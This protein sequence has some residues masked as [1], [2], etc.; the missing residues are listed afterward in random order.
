MQHPVSQFPGG[1]ALQVRLDALSPIEDN[2][3]M[4]YEVL[5]SGTFWRWLRQLRDH[6]A[7]ALIAVRID[8][9]V[10]GNFGDH[11][12]VGGAVSE[13]RINR[14]PGYRVYFTIRDRTVVV[15]LSGGDKSSQQEDISRA[16]RMVEQL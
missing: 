8:R 7:R 16:Q 2:A 1:P 10:E 3:R 5:A 13:L 11:R 9:M 4:E 14:G 12:S 6:Q 15:L